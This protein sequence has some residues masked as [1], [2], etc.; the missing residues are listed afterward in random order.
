MEKQLLIQML[1]L[2]NNNRP[3]K[4]TNDL[5]LQIAVDPELNDVVAITDFSNEFYSVRAINY[6]KQCFNFK[7]L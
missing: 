5:A 2:S 4:V 3:F 6:I 1:E 7:L